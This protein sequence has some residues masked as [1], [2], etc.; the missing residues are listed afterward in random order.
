MPHKSQI[1]HAKSQSVLFRCE[2][3]LGSETCALT[4]ILPGESEAK[5]EMSNLRLFCFHDPPLGPKNYQVI[6]L[7]PFT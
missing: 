7:P 1:D 4:S 2:R 3:R 6:I 5:P